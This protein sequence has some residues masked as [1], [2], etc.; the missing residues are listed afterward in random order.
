MYYNLKKQNINLIKK[1]TYDLVSINS[2]TNTKGEVEASLYIYNFLSSLDYFKHNRQNLILQEL[3]DNLQ[4]KNVI[5]ILKANNL[6]NNNVVVLLS[7]FDTVDIEDYQNLKKYAFDID[8][9]TSKIKEL[10]LSNKLDNNPD[11]KEIVDD[12][13][14]NRYLFG[15]GLL[16]MKAGVAVNLAIIKELAENI[17]KFNGIVI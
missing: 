17:D 2:I 1:L 12:I 16:D 11:I 13:E 14:S 10:Y 15:R 4:R 9:L 5:A 8:K 3:G 7:H 6:K